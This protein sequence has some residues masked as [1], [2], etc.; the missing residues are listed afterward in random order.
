MHDPR[1]L[2][3]TIP[4]PF[5]YRDHQRKR[6]HYSLVSVWHVDPERDGSDDSCGWFKRARHGDPAVLE[7][8][9]KE[10]GQDW[11]HWYVSEHSKETRLVGYFD[12]TD[13]DPLMTVHGI[14]LNLFWL[15]AINVFGGRDKAERYMRKDLF[16]I[17][18]FAEN[19]TDSMMHL[20]RQTYGVEPRE[21]RIRSAAA[22][23]YGWILRAQRRWW[24]HP[25]WHVHHWEL[26]IHPWQTLRRW[27]FDRCCRCGQRFALGESPIS[28]SWDYI[29]P[30]SFRS[31]VGLYHDTCGNPASVPCG[32]MKTNDEAES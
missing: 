20:I 27:L 3:F 12:P 2:A 31:T 4:S 11:D 22:M 28:S 23:I 24:Q 1:T 5:F 21:E 7:K 30:K 25:R 10:F 9:V 6:R 26:Q 29:K 32:V 15:A 8:I 19:P 13:G 16:R 18:H 14:T 17:L